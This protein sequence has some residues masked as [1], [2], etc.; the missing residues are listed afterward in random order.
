MLDVLI[1]VPNPN[2]ELLVRA[3]YLNSIG[4]NLGIAG[5]ASKA[6]AIFQRLLAAVPDDPRGN[7]MYGTFLAGAGKSQEAL[8]YL[9]KAL[10]LGVADAAYSLGM[11]HLA[12]GDGEQ[13]LTHLEDYKRRKPADTSVDAIL[14]AVRNGKIEINR[15]SK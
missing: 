11:T 10:E 1:N 12:L 3:G 6:N 7:Y 4:H 5:S 9:V 2:P 8:P 13:A 14:N 15:T